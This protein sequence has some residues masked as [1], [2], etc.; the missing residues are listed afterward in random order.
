MFDRGFTMHE[1]LSAFKLINMN[2]RMYD[3]VMSRFLSPDPII[4]FPENSQSYNSY[5]YV[6]NNPLRFTDPSGF[7]AEGDS[8]ANGKNTNWSEAT[9]KALNIVGSSDDKEEESISSFNTDYTQTGKTESITEE[10]SVSDKT[11]VVEG[12]RRVGTNG[13]GDLGYIGNQIRD[14]AGSDFS[15]SLFENY[16]TGGGDMTL[17]ADRFNAIANAAKRLQREYYFVTLSNGQ[18]GVKAITDFYGNEEYSPAFGRA[19]LYYNQRGQ[20]VGFSDVYNFDPKAW[21]VRP[22]SAEI[23]TRMVNAAGVVY[24]AQP[25]NIT[26][27]IGVDF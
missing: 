11:K 18:S 27:G 9:A 3:P 8:T 4:Q 19:T 23:K 25:F 17:S 15:K 7:L 26:Y 14:R 24:G 1:H 5:S 6:L 12:D 20:A 2:G 22:K 13:G 16:W 21:G 10:N